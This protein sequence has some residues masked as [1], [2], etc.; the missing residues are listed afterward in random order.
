M[1]VLKNPESL[2]VHHIRFYSEG[3]L[4]DGI[5]EISAQ[6]GFGG[7]DRKTYSCMTVQ[8]P[9]PDGWHWYDKEFGITITDMEHY[10]VKYDFD[11]DNDY[12][13]ELDKDRVMELVKIGDVSQ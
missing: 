10:G 8:T 6:N 2:Q 5:I 7:M 12:H 11:R 1:K 13:K 4:V 3:D 9:N